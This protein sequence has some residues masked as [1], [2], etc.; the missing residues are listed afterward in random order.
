MFNALFHRYRLSA[1]AIGVAL[2]VIAME[3]TD[4]A[5]Q[6]VMS[7]NITRDLALGAIYGL[8]WFALFPF[9]ERLPHGA[10]IALGAGSFFLISIVSIIGVVYVFYAAFFWYI[11]VPIGI[12]AGE[13]SWRL[14]RWSR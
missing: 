11:Y 10:V 14:S 2:G 9:L 13:A 1:F 12:A 6:G 4:I 7:L 5:N 3:T 8:F